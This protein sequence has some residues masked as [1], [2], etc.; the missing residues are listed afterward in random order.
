MLHDPTLD[1]T[2]AQTERTERRSSPR[3]PCPAELVLV[4]F[5]DTS[6]PVRYSLLDVSEGG[7]RIQTT[8]PIPTGTTGMVV[9][10]LPEGHEV[11]EPVMVVRIR[12]AKPGVYDVGLRRM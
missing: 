9:R 8:T 7:Y 5:Y 11:E 1:K 12:R 2:T 4:W 10:L 3:V 6:T